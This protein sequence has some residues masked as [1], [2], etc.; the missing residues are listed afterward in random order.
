[1]KKLMFILTVFFAFSCGDDTK[2]D[3]ALNVQAESSS[4]EIVD[5]EGY[6]KMISEDADK[7]YVVNFWATWCKPCIQELPAF[8]K[9]NE[10]YSDKNVE[11]ILVSLDFKTQVDSKLKPFIKKKNIASRVVLMDDSKENEWLPK[12]SQSWSGAIPATVIKKGSKQI[13]YEQSFSYEELEEA[14]KNI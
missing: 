4:I 6:E 13:F 1:M 11:V 5:F 12:V 9:L 14:L 10:A 8:E 7:T 3:E 2:K